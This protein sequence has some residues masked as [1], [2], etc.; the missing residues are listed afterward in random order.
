ML[1]GFLFQSCLFCGKDSHPTY[2]PTDRNQQSTLSMAYKLFFCLHAFCQQWS[3]QARCVLRVYN[4]VQ[5]FDVKPVELIHFCYEQPRV[6]IL[7]SF[8][9]LTVGKLVMSC[10][11]MMPVIL[12][13]LLLFHCSRPSSR[14]HYIS[15]IVLN[16]H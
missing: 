9:S 14:K 6:E 15:E 8:L 10:F 1:L 5:I 4:S 11:H 7:F 13:R 12:G 2:L 3:K 16:N